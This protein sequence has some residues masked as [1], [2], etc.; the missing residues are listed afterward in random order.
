MLVGGL[1]NKSVATFDVRLLTRTAANQFLTAVATLPD[2]TQKW[3]LIEI[4]GTKLEIVGTNPAPF[5]RQPEAQG[6]ITV[7]A[8]KDVP[9]GDPLADVYVRGIAPD[10]TFVT[11]NERSTGQDGNAIFTIKAPAVPKLL[12]TAEESVAVVQGSTSVTPRD[13]KIKVI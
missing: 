12:A 4:K 9:Q 2:G 3:A 11:G 10:W 6:T 7:K 5:E 13:V 8:T 1:P